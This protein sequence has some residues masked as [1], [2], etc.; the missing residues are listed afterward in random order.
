[1]A[2]PGILHSAA[3]TLG[4]TTAGTSS[5]C[6][7]YLTLVKSSGSHSQ[8]QGA[9]V[10]CCQ[11]GSVDSP[12][13]RGARYRTEHP[14]HFQLCRSFGKVENTF[15]PTQ[16]SSFISTFHR[17]KSERAKVSKS[18]Y[19]KKERALNISKPRYISDSLLFFR[20]WEGPGMYLSTKSTWWHQWKFN[21][22]LSVAEPASFS[23]KA[24]N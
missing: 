9:F 23:G 16:N 6:W 3:H 1:M 19:F 11:L 4:E 24:H 21:R 20:F 7:L 17:S 15:C 22:H 2:G 18:N 5:C 8:S 13:L 14:V 12:V 10:L